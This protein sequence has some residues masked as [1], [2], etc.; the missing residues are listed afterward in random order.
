MARQF[1]TCKFARTPGFLRYRHLN[2]QL[3]A[4]GGDMLSSAIILPLG[5]LTDGSLL[6]F[7]REAKAARPP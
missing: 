1:P 6:R 2:C 3:N 7:L 5:R 4:T